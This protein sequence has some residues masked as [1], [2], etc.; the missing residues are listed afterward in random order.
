MLRGKRVVLLLWFIILHCG[1]L[2]AFYGLMSR[3]FWTFL[4]YI[5]LVALVDRPGDLSLFVSFLLYLISELHPFQSVCS[6]V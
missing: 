5:L 1:V 2:N 6:L 3:L 4:A